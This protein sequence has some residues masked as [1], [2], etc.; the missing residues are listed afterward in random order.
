MKNVKPGD[1]IIVKEQKYL[2]HSPRT[3]QWMANEKGSVLSVNKKTITVLFDNYPDERNYVD[4]DDF[5]IL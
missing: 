5:I 4:Y 3:K 2:F 1:K